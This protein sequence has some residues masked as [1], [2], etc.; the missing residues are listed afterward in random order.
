MAK[1]NKSNISKCI[2]GA[3]AVGGVI[4]IAAIAPNSLQMLKLFGLGK[5]EYKARSAYQALRR[6]REQRLV[7]IKETEKEILVNITE[8]GK[9]RLLRYN[10]DE[11][12]IK[13]PYRWDKKWRIV[14]FD[15]PEKRRD[16]REALRNKL[17]DLGFIMLQKSIFVFPFPCKDEVD[18]VTEIFQ[19]QKYV[20]YFEATNINV[21]TKLLLDFGLI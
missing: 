5:K 17:Q 12:A 2:L 8:K 15:I 7:E 16:T 18:F 3:L 19:I 1:I 13:K 6:L 4:A 20:T 21:E 10:F 14:S 9:K 11:M